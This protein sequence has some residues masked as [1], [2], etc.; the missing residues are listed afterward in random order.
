MIL[1]EKHIAT[2][3]INW[4]DKAANL[5][6]IAADLNI[7]L[8]GLV[9][10]DD[11]DFEVNLIR[12]SLPAVEVI[13]MPP[14]R[15]VEYRNILASCGLFDSV[16]LSAEDRNRSAM[17]KA[18]A[19]RKKL[20]AQAIDLETYLKSLG[21]ILEIRFADEFAIPRI[22]QLTQKTNQFNLTTRR[23]SEDDIETLANAAHSDVIYVRLQ[24]RLGDSG[25]VGVFILKYENERA[26][27][28]TFLLSCRVLGR[29]VED[30]LVI[31]ATKLAKKRGSGAIIGEYYA[32]NKNGQVAD[33]YVKHGFEIAKDATKLGGQA[34]LLS[35]D[36]QIRTEPALFEKV[37]SEID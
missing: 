1:N 21:T 3:Q 25:I 20:R 31:Q 32:T 2:A 15:A 29:A 34:F 26:I 30:V 13:Q 17:Y 36:G 16:T 24:D 6:Q 23:Y 14:A 33:F 10:L 22:A 28:D 8:D 11:S 9:F 37:E 27:V 12:K 35:L 7:G 18:E 19:T 5:R 4:Q